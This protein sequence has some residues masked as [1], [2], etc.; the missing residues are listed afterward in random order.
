M[1]YRKPICIRKSR[2]ERAVC[3]LCP[4]PS[5]TA[6][7]L[8]A[9]TGCERLAACWARKSLLARLALARLSDLLLSSCGAAPA[10]RRDVRVERRRVGGQL[11]AASARSI[12][13]F[14][15]GHGWLLDFPLGV[16]H[17]L[18]DEKG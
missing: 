16:S 14:L 3:V 1:S 4:C 7:D 18:L 9:F 6:V 12:T 13:G 8:A 15:K 2:R 5:S 10:S 17:V 11:G